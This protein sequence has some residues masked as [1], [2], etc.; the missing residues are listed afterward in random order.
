MFERKMQA[1][2]DI[3]S[4][5]EEIPRI[6][7]MTL[8]NAEKQ[9]YADFPPF[10]YVECPNERGLLSKENFETVIEYEHYTFNGKYEY[11]N[12]LKEL[13]FNTEQDQARRR[14]RQCKLAQ[15]T[16]TRAPD[17]AKADLIMDN[18]TLDNYI[19]SDT[20]LERQLD[21]VNYHNVML[22][23]YRKW[24]ELFI[25]EDARTMEIYV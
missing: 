25:F 18:I 20:I 2:C 9:E 8:T 11:L 17:P 5:A 21:V 24:M 15:R 22:C 13:A 23:R 4:L 14:I 19:P 12:E 1:I 10:C 6:P 16:N 3:Q 7:P